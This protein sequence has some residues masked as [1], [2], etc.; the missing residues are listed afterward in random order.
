M[1][2]QRG[3]F[4][5]NLP[6]HKETRRARKPL[7][8]IETLALGTELLQLQPSNHV[9]GA[10]AGAGAIKKDS[11]KVRGHR[12]AYIGRREGGMFQL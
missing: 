11:Y 3:Q 6:S 8:H 4:S 10:A 12:R 7:P 5:Q 1:G 9:Q 2:S